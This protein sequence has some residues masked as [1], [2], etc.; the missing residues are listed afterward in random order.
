[1]VDQIYERAVD[2]L[3]AELGDEIVGLDVDGGNCFGFNPVAASIWRLLDQPRSLSAL[4]SALVE[5]YEVDEEQCG[6]ELEELLDD[7]I[8]RRLVRVR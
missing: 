3:E 1:M 6:R 8:E 7:L 4:K 5:E 2:L